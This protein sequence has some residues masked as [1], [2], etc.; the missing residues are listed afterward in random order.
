MTMISSTSCRRAR[1]ASLAGPSLAVLVLAL[2]SPA[3]VRAQSFNGPGTVTSGS[4][5]ITTGAGT[6]NVDI[7]SN[8]VVIDWTTNAPASGTVVFQPAGTTATF[9]ETS[10]FSG[11]DYTVLNRIIPVDAVSGTPTNASI[12]FD[13]TV[14]STLFGVP[15]GNV[16][17]YSPTG[18]IL[19]STATFNVGSLVLTTNPIDTTGGLYGSGGEIRFRGASGSTGLVQIQAGASITAS[20]SPQVPGDQAYVALVAPRVEQGGKVQADGPIAYVAAED[21]DIT[22]NAGLF[23][24]SI[25]TGTTDSNGV[26]HTGT[27]T[28]PASAGT[29]DPRVIYMIAVPKNDGLTML[30]GGSIGYAAA[31]SA[32]ND[33]S[34][35][36]LSA[37][38]GL[39]YDTGNSLTNPANIAIGDAVFSNVT[40]AN[41]TDAITVTPTSLTQFDRFTTLDA[42]NSVSLT[43]DGG[44]QIIA[45]DTAGLPSDILTPP[46][47]AGYSLD[48]FSGHD[49]TGGA[50][51]LTTSN[52]GSLTTAGRLR[53]RADGSDSSGSGVDGTGGTITVN[54]LSGGLAA[55]DLEISATGTG[56]FG[57]TG[58]SN[59]VGGTVT[60]LS[61]SKFNAG[62]L[63][64]NVEGTGGFGDADGG[65]G[66]GGTVSLTAS[67]GGSISTQS[68]SL[69]AQGFGG[70]GT[71]NGGKGSGGTIST[72]VAGNGSIAAPAAFDAV[73]TGNSG[74]SEGA[75]GDALGGS[76]SLAG[77]LGLLDFSDVNLTATAIGDPSAGAGSLATGGTVQVSLA[78]TSQNWNN[79]T[80]D[81]SATAGQIFVPGLPAGSAVG[82]LASGV[83][84]DVQGVTLNLTGA[85]TLTNNAYGQVGN[86]GGTFASAGSAT[87]TVGGGGALNTG[88]GLSVTADAVFNIIALPGSPD[89]T[90]DM[91]GGTAS[92]LIDG[93]S[94]STPTLD[95]SAK[96]TG[97]GAL[98]GAGSAT[99]GTA[100]VVASG[101]GS[102]DVTG[103]AAL[104]LTGTL[105][106]NASGDGNYST[107]INSVFGTVE[108]GFA[109]AAQGGIALLQLDSGTITVA[110]AT[111]INAAG[112]GG[113]SATIGGADSIGTGTGGSARVALGGGTM[114]LGGNLNIDAS[115][116]G[117]A[118]SG[119]ARGA[120]GQGGLAAL[121]ATGGTLNVNGA[122]LFLNADGGSGSISGTTTGSAGDATGGAARLTTQGTA[123]IA[124]PGLVQVS[125]TGFS[126]SGS[127]P[128]GT[129]GLATGGSATLLAQGGTMAL[130][131][132]DVTANADFGSGLA[133]QGG[134]NTAGIARVET[135]GGTITVTGDISINATAALFA[136]LSDLHGENAAGGQALLLAGNAGTIGVSGITSVEA[137]GLGGFDT[138]AGGQG[139]NGT[140][141][142]A[143]IEALTGGGITLT[144][145]ATIYADGYGGD[146]NG[147]GGLGGNGVGGGSTVNQNTGGTIHFLG[148]LLVDSNAFGGINAV[149]STTSGLATGGTSTLTSGAGTLL[150]DGDATLASNPTGGTNPGRTAAPTVAGFIALG[151]GT[152]SP[153][154]AIAIGGSLSATAIGDAARPD[155]TGFGAKFDS[156]ATTVGG[157]T[158]INTTG[159]I[160]LSAANGGSLATTG[161]LTV[162]SD[163][164]AISSTGLLSSGSASQFQAPGGIALGTLVSGSTTTLLSSAGPVSVIDL[165]STG[166][167]TVSGLS[168]D[169]GSSSGLTVASAAATGGDLTIDVA[170][171]LLLAP[172]DGTG[173]VT[174]RSRTASVTANSPVTGSSI[175]IDAGTNAAI[176]AAL[177]APSAIGVTAGNSI[178][179]GGPVTG[180][181]ISLTAGQNVTANSALT[182]TSLIDIAAGG[183]IIT[184]GP[185]DP[186]VLRMTAG[187]SI[188]TNGTAVGGAITLISGTNI[189]INA[190]MIADTALSMTAG[191]TIGINALA[192]GAQV[193][194]TSADIAIGANGQIGRRGTTQTVQFIN[195]AGANPSFLG[196]TGGTGGYSLDAGEFL[197]VFAD[198]TIGF[199]V[200]GATPAAVSVGD[201]ALTFGPTGNIGTG[202]SL[203]LD[204]AG[205]ITASGNVA[206]TTSSTTDTLRVDAARFDVATDTGSVALLD[207]AGSPQ[208]TLN[209]TAGTFAAGTT[210]AL[211]LLDPG[212]DIAANTALLDTPVQVNGGVTAGSINANVTDG[213]Y[214]Q[215]TGTATT[216]ADRRGFTARS[217]TIGTGSSATQIVINGVTIDAAGALAT[218]LGTIGT[219]T[220][221]GSIAFAGGAFDPR[222]SINGCIIGRACRISLLPTKPDLT[223]PP[224]PP[225]TRD[226]GTFINDA[227]L[228]VD[229]RKSDP[230]TLLPLVDEPVTGVGNEDLW[231]DRCASDKKEACERGN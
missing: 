18:I 217:L 170:G 148:G 139:G 182:A 38:H 135:A 210:A 195:T 126:G 49:T 33:G 86:A 208:G 17:F 159:D 81:A 192:S 121:D 165:L 65:N 201:L 202:G 179:L 64:V 183:A 151:T 82:N 32:S 15:D 167:L 41:A 71:F 189:A 83:S 144:G 111:T 116:F 228:N 224:D 174:L 61:Q 181:S 197:R 204:S 37:G 11:T 93:G 53:L 69:D 143:R 8:E 1:R 40:T 219:I 107:N 27:T 46:S 115:G 84:L 97:L 54:A 106:I 194:A 177:A 45:S 130:G 176:N 102:L 79:L 94:I 112:T 147:T 39:G 6:T 229:V 225:G 171:N 80:A 190:D 218:G 31:A 5:S 198:G 127:G 199:T 52:S 98:L 169:I 59:G 193:T 137:N 19:G 120:A 140:G 67:G 200:A 119:G 117:G 100:Q 175:A 28:G 76:V 24:I 196:G 178:N 187:S 9:A 188:T 168:V 158:F 230:D 118:I 113:P 88:T 47:G 87:V 16:W 26:V 122:G 29:T 133:A 30:L 13:G 91:T 96:A 134:T 172:V 103:N 22:M 156:A 77:T 125:A 150:I 95:V 72:L 164:G 216:Y 138:L 25:N 209:V 205:R 21:A 221:N 142:T 85:A 226:G 12:E 231:G 141:G 74:S 184:N 92:V 203:A 215:N 157:N 68:I 7:V 173:A 213:F 162:T 161:T 51:T 220:I 66:N 153:G 75:G 20:R 105:T 191:G 44:A 10:G 50:I 70:F 166:P 89:F 48:I 154:G 2:A 163:A 186:A 212:G 34:A 227:I 207:A 152:A 123:S 104:G 43:A 63:T 128:A 146:A 62:T 90:P 23:D 206:L 60:I 42:F 132:T 160:D 155:G 149:D 214:V 99:G 109:P 114:S 223:G 57:I 129:G 36:I 108:D 56:G 4:A 180:G 145:D 136:D 73:A 14:N 3:A 124:V 211:A 78:G 110:D 58:G 101:G 185:I 35:V 131:T 55:S 222:S